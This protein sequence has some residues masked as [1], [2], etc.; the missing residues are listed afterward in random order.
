MTLEQMRRQA[1]TG[2]W[3]RMNWWPDH[4]TPGAMRPGFVWSAGDRLV[5]NVSLRPAF[6]RGGF[7]IGNVCVH[8]D[9]RGR[10]IARDLMV[11]ALTEMRQHGGRWAAL[12]VREDNLAAQ[13]LYA[14]L[15]F[16]HIGRTIRFVRQ[17]PLDQPPPV[18]DIPEVAWRRGRHRDSQALFDLA[19]ASVPEVLHSA[20]ELR[21]TD[22]A[23]GWARTVNEWLAGKS[24]TWWVVIERERVSGAVRSLRFRPAMPDRLEVLLDRDSSPDLGRALVSRGLASLRRG[25]GKV[26]Q[27]VLTAEQGRIV[28]PLEEFGFQRSHVLCHLRLGLHSPATLFHTSPAA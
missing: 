24:E 1:R 15:G 28:S 20:L 13:G 5:G 9:W 19:R 21:Q 7:I 2:S 12:E 10:G 25:G 14:R 3:G 11:R 18:R 6:Q 8:P 27:A 22:Y 4:T 23:P 16:A 17:G 26:V